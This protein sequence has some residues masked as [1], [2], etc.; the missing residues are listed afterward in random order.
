MLAAEAEGLV[1]PRAKSDRATIAIARIR[2][3]VRNSTEV[4][5]M[6]TNEQET[7]LPG[8]RLLAQAEEEIA[9][10][11]Y[12]KGAG[13]VWQATM[14]ALAAVAERHGMPCRD[15]EEAR[16]VAKRLDRIGKAIWGPSRDPG[17]VDGGVPDDV[18]TVALTEPDV[19]DYW[20]Q[21]R[22]DLADSFREH[23]EDLEDFSGTQFEW[24]PD[25][26]VVYL[27]PVRSFI[28]SLN[29]QQTVDTAR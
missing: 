24:E 28:E 17:P 6:T 23:Y 3:A 19:S 7:A 21:L 26:Y 8:E 22:F 27:E 13:L 12:H 18:H 20:Y 10:G 11:N 25:E 15:R 1:V 5:E 9:R 2:P 29:R 14:A 16:L 4:S